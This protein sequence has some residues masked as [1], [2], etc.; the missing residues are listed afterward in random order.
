[1]SEQVYQITTLDAVIRAKLLYG[2]DSAQLPPA[3]PYFPIKR[4][5]KTV[6]M[7]TTYVERSNSNAEAFRRVNEQI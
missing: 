3:Q 7:T 1:M 4:F 5:E 6:K 2:L